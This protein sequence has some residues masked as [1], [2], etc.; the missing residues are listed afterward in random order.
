MEKIIA[1]DL[2]DDLFNNLDGIF[3]K[4]Y[5]VLRKHGYTGPDGEDDYAVPGHGIIPSHDYI[6]D[7]EDNQ[8]LMNELNDL[9][10]DN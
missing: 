7:N 2:V 3:E 4:Y 8:E 10:K 6:Y 9:V 1:D 5:E